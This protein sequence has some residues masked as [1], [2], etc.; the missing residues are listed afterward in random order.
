MCIS[1]VL[2]MEDF[3]RSDGDGEHIV[4][5]LTGY[6]SALHFSGGKDQFTMKMI[7]R[8]PASIC[9]RESSEDTAPAGAQVRV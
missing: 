5:R 7:T 2:V 8:S 1:T 6:G 3:A 4:S 9:M